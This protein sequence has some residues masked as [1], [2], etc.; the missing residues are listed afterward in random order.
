MC[1]SDSTLSSVNRGEV[2]TVAGRR[3]DTPEQ[4]DNAAEQIVDVH[5]DSD[6]I[7]EYSEKLKKYV[8]TIHC[9]S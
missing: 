8:W 7:K 5:I 9:A 4:S 1:S 3:A 2:E 6:A